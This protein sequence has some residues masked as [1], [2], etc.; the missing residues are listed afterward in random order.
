MNVAILYYN[1]TIFH[2]EYFSRRYKHSSTNLSKTLYF[3]I[4]LPRALTYRSIAHVWQLSVFNSN[5]NIYLYS[6]CTL[7][8]VFIIRNAFQSNIQIGA[9]SFWHLTPTGT[10]TQIKHT[11]QNMTWM[12]LN[13]FIPRFCE[14]TVCPGERHTH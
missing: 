5:I 14:M 1:V 7:V 9:P 13:V 8:S 11:A 10:F 2:P 4:T 6:A 12:H 3:L